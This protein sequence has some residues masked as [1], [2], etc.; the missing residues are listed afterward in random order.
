MKCPYCGVV[1]N[2]P[3]TPAATY[4]IPTELRERIRER[5]RLDG[6]TET[7]VVRAALEEY[8]NRG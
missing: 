3:K 8:L 2:Q 1:P 5:A 4:R 6:V 7:D